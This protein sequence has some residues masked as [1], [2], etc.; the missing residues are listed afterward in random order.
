MITKIDRGELNK[1]FPYFIYKQFD[2]NITKNY[3][4]FNIPNGYNYFIRRIICKWPETDGV[5][6][7]IS[8][9]IKIQFYRNSNAVNVDPVNLSLLSSPAR[10]GNGIS[11]CSNN[12]FKSLKI[13]D[14]L[15]PYSGTI[16]AEIT[17]V[18]VANNYPDHIDIVMQGYYIRKEGENG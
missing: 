8:R 3:F 18:D 1:L 17:G 12:Q 5:M 7:S 6:T 15:I 11:D 2:G 16:H 13:L 14:L 4:L 9:D 10:S